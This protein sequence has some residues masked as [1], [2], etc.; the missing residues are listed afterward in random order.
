MVSHTDKIRKKPSCYDLGQR[1]HRS[2]NKCRDLRQVGCPNEILEDQKTERRWATPLGLGNA[3]HWPSKKHGAPCDV[4]CPMTWSE[5]VEKKEWPPKP[6]RWATTNYYIIILRDEKIRE[7]VSHPARIWAPI[8]LSSKKLGGPHE[9]RLPNDVSWIPLQQNRRVVHVLP[10]LYLHV[11]SWR[12]GWIVGRRVDI[13]HLFHSLTISW[14]K[15][16][17]A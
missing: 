4:G 9:V 11:G 6:W 8:T 13:V 1:L 7:G 14:S 15:H 3:L 5:G 16:T 2:L 17:V 12:I 10:S